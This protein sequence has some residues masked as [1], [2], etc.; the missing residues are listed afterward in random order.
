MRKT[1]FLALITV[2]FFNGCKTFLPGKSLSQNKAAYSEDLSEYRPEFAPET[3]EPEEEKEDILITSQDST[4]APVNETL[5]YL[6]D[7]ATTFSK[8]TI[9]YIDGFTIQVYGGDNRELAKNYQLNILR[10]F[11]DCEPRMVFEQPN[12][13]VRLGLFYSRLEAQH[14]FTQVKEVFPKAIL[15]PTRINIDN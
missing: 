6:L 5:N 13:K 10:H 1:I 9:K 8:E 14:Q 4:T 11:P 12:Y 2:V 7:T 15:I 3:V